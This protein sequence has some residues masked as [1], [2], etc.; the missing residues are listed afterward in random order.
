MKREPATSRVVYGGKQVSVVV[1]DWDGREREVVRHPG[2]VA[3]VAVDRGG[4]VTLVRQFR[5]PARTHV[6]ELPAGTLEDGEDPLACARRELAEET[7]L[8]GGRWRQLA[9]VWTSPGFLDERMSLFAAEDVEPGERALE[10][11]ED[12]ELVRIPVAELE[13]RLGEVEDAKTVAGLLL[14]LA[15][16]RKER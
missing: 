12:V 1:E 10:A 4:V 16:V 15:E 5:E 14:Y 8:K 11:D 6:L 9:A 2:S 3:V 13:A 7:G